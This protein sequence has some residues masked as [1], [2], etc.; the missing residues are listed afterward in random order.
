M[1][2]KANQELVERLA[3]EVL[4]RHNLAALDDIFHADYIE[5]DPPPGMGPGIEGL[6]QWL[7][8]WI[9]AFPDA[10][11]TVEEQIAD[12]DHVWTR[13]TWRG[14]H[15]GPFLGIPATGRQATVAA[16]TIDQVT[17]GKI[18]HSRIVMDALGLMQQ[19]GVI[20]DPT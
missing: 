2:G 5:A 4:T 12:D 15:E 13:S 18:A 14:T 8:M 9:A 19:L 17:D 10:R 6:R 3:D 20:P 16:W 11:W 1:S 7:A